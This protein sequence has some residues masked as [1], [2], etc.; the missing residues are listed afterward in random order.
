[1]DYALIWYGL[2]GGALMLL[3]GLVTAII[4]WRDKK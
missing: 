4:E 3:V 1:M 2:V